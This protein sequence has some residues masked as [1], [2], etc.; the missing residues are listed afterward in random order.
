MFVISQAPQSRERD[1]IPFCWVIPLIESVI[2]VIVLWDIYIMDPPFQGP[3]LP[4]LGWEHVISVTCCSA[5]LGDYFPSV[6]PSL[7]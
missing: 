5:H 3:A 4:L 6:H 7:F 1:H 2:V